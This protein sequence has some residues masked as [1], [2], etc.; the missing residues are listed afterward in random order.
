MRDIFGC[1]YNIWALGFFWTTSRGLIHSLKGFELRAPMF[2]V[3]YTA[4]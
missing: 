4:A 2:K 1:I 3:V